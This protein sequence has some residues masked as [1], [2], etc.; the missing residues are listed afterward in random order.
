VGYSTPMLP[1]LGQRYVALRPLGRGGQ[2]RV[3]LAADQRLAGRQVA[4]KLLAPGGQA[5]LLQREFAFLS[6]LRHP[7]LA[8]VHDLGVTASGEPY[9]V[10][11]FVEGVPLDVWW[12]DRPLHEALAAIA[13]LLGTIDFLH[14]RGVA[15][16]D[17]KPDNVLVAGPAV[18]LVDFGL[19]VR[20]GT[21]PEVSGTPGYI[22]PE[23][24][25]R[26]PLVASS[27][28]YALGV[29]L[30][31]RLWHR[32]PFVG[33]A[34]A[35][36]TRQLREEVVLPASDAP[37]RL[38]DLVGQLLAREPSQRPASAADVLAILEEIEGGVGRTA[39]HFL[40]GQGLPEP[41]LVGREA[42]LEAIRAALSETTD[43]AGQVHGLAMI[44]EPGEGRTRLL[45]EIACLAQLRGLRVLH[46]VPRGSTS[47]VAAPRDPSA[48][49]ALAVQRAV[50][51]LGGTTV[52]TL[53]LV[54]DVDDPLELQILLALCRLEA[55]LLLVVTARAGSGAAQE[56]TGP[57]TRLEL[58][59]LDESQVAT[60]VASMLPAGWTTKDLT[61][62]AYRVS[63]GNPLLATELTRAAVARQLAE[64]GPA[65]LAAAVDAE[66]VSARI[67]QL[68]SVRVR[69]LSEEQRRVAT[70]VAIFEAG[71]PTELLRELDPGLPLAAIDALQLQGILR[72]LPDGRLQVVAA[73]LGRALVDGL[74][75]S[76]RA[77]LGRRGL[78]ILEASR[79][80][81][82]QRALL[83]LA[84][85]IAGER[86]EVVIEGARQSRRDLDLST[87]RRLFRAALELLESSPIRGAD[88]AEVREE[89]VAV[90]LA[91][92]QSQSA[93]DVWS[94]ALVRADDVERT[95]LL[96]CL[97]EAQL[98]AG[99]A[100]DAVRT[101]E[102]ATA[103]GSTGERV[104]A[105][106]GRALL[107]AGRYADALQVARGV[108]D[109]LDPRSAAEA[110][111]T[112]GLAHY[113]LGE[114]APALV[115]LRRS[116]E[117]ATQVGDRLLLARVTNSLAMVHQR[118]AELQLA[119]ERYGECLALAR[120]LGHLPF[121]ATFL[122]NLA[123]VA[124]LQGDYG[125][126]LERYEQSLHV[127]ERF[128]GGRELAQVHH[129]LGRLLGL[130]GQESR[131]RTHL[132]RAVTLAEAHS[133]TALKGES[134]LVEAELAMAAGR[135]AQAAQA[136]DAAE[137][138]FARLGDAAAADE[139][140]VARGRW[141]L[142]SGL[143]EE[144]LTLAR[145]VLERGARDARALQ[146]LVLAGTA[147]RERPGG[148]PTEALRHLG[149]ALRLAEETDARGSLVEIHWQLHLASVAA[150]DTAGE[151][152]HREAA[153]ALLQQQIDRLPASLRRSFA[154]QPQWA[155]VLDAASSVAPAALPILGRAAS[156]VAALDSGL[157]AALLEISK[158]LNAEPDLKRLL[159]RI[160]D[161]AVELA[162]AERGFLLMLRE[163][164]LEIQV[165]RNIDQ[166]TVRRKE[167]KV[168]R[169]IA[170]QAISS[171]RAVIAVDAMDDDRFR[172]FLSVHNLRLRSILCVPMTIRREVRGAIYLDN[173]FQTEAFTAQHAELLAAL[174][175]QAGLAVG[176]WE[177][178][179]ENRQR[180]LEL[181][182]SREELQRKSLELQRAVD[183]QSQR[184]DELAELARSRQGEL[185]GRYQFENLVGQSAAMRELFRL[186]DRVKDSTAPA[187]L[188][189]ES[190]TGKELVARALHYNGPRR[191]APFITVN[192][193]ALP[194]TLL[195]SELFGYEKGA[196]TGAE[197]QH[198]G[199]FE[200]SDSG[201]LFL[202]EVGDMPL[203]L[204]VK[205]LRVLQEKRFSRI[206][207]ERELTSDFRLLA[208]SNR[209][210]QQ[211]VQEGKFRQD[212][213]F[214][215]N[216]ILLRLPPL[217]ERRED[218]PLLVDFLL[219]RHGA[220]RQVSRGALRT[221]VEHDWP[222]NVRELENEILRALA[223]GGAVISPE[224]LSPHL[225]QPSA[226]LTPRSGREDL[227]LKEAIIHLEREHVLT[228][229]RECRGSVTEAAR[230]LGMTRVGL[231]KLLKR[232]GLG[233]ESVSRD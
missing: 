128:G 109:S 66:E 47:P 19:A 224:D 168:S 3:Y 63:G 117:L 71:A 207:G 155:R 145:R 90:L 107:I 58:G 9:M 225:T 228:A 215:I 214:R 10:S 144:A 35:I 232:H 217:R 183:Q 7:G 206:G 13:Q 115:A 105:Q 89:L 180:Q 72:Q 65:H 100:P 14:R 194:P 48:E 67:A 76:E 16:R 29:I 173:R 83:L 163:E 213:F 18:K 227:T 161:H 111:H 92:G 119:A 221:L 5:D 84:C 216:V 1:E 186:I 80:P 223:L 73:S 190:G 233:R 203:D 50:T 196:F 202:D 114:D 140:T 96:C 25:V 70:A 141:K 231:H 6:R 31:Q 86:P 26:R 132:R 91:L 210:L 54:D 218:I 56:L 45:E 36:A 99:R 199:L 17:I 179:E 88:V 142:R 118:R 198:Q 2:G 167:F 208:A 187:L 57:M 162:G 106:R 146:G 185:E 60:L 24:L 197:R 171:G 85:G 52:W 11:D 28:L 79:A 127:A 103:S 15:H 129:N 12:R 212:L 64:G 219:Q 120:E 157:L 40:A 33:D 151:R 191:Q 149:A 93:I 41:Q 55:P 150:G 110:Q 87:S 170:E 98:R 62:L 211:L 113:Y 136:L 159:E 229:L 178:L 200:R 123:S 81:A 37:E 222:G 20:L 195:E 172:D 148:S 226:S 49:Q 154:A 201:S 61:A 53:V 59:P 193:G 133:W 156:R 139:V 174:A 74:E 4:V 177:I 166:E 182:R 130:L 42:A 32:P 95:V 135:L 112:I 124:D 184:L 51:E 69:H 169:S 27:D 8:A 181:E 30:H 94:A 147:E 102:G 46:G 125:A 44:G 38:R 101:L 68:A 82:A 152:Q 104:T 122:M 188:F 230:R 23:A 121:E 21:T 126:A 205:L 34:S 175:D 209:N 176:N 143:P 189:G 165:A 131:A 220:G 160:I 43:R 137:E 108:G 158:E 192:C 134:V 97:A 39:A 116:H 75:A 77:E 138:I 204:Q 78:V 153:R 22:A 164:Q